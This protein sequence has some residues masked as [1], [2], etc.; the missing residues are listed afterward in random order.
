MV[1]ATKPHSRPFTYA[2][3]MLINYAG[4]S[5]H[6]K[7]FFVFFVFLVV[8]KE[9]DNYCKNGSCAPF[10]RRPKRRAR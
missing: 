9:A 8:I 1:N 2:P 3:N 4:Q 7:S 5:A 10:S 6:D